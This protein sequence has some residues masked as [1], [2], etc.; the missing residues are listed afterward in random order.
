MTSAGLELGLTHS[1]VAS[2]RGLQV[3]VCGAS[4]VLRRQ[5]SLAHN[6][7]LLLEGLAVHP[8]LQHVACVPR[9]ALLRASIEAVSA[10]STT[11]ASYCY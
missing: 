3:R 10:L 1:W 4:G 8:L 7:V 5:L 11:E 9:K 2:S 6:V